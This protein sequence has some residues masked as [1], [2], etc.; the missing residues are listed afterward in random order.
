MKR[1]LFHWYIVVVATSVVAPLCA[2]EGLS[3]QL[4]V[5]RVQSILSEKCWACHGNDANN[6]EGGLDLRSLA[7]A[8]QGGDSGKPAMVVGQPD[9]SPLILASLRTDDTWSAMP[10]KEAEQLTEQQIEWLKSWIETGAAWPDEKRI[11]E[12][13]RSH[14]DAWSAEDGVTVTTSGGLSDE[15]NRR[16]YQPESL[17]AYQPVQKPIVAVTNSAAIDQ[18]I[19]DRLPDGLQVAPAADARTLIRRASFDLIGLPPAPDEIA[20]FEQAFAADEDA[21]VAALIDRLLS[22]PHYGE[23]MAQHW[24]DVV[25]YADSSGFAN[26]YERGNAWRYRDYVVRAFN[27]DKPYDQ[28]VREQLAGDEMDPDDP[29]MLIATGFLRMGPWEL[30]GM[31]VARIARQRFLDDVT[32]SVGETFLAHSLQCARCHDHKFDPVPTRDYYSIQA[33]FATTQLVERAAPFLPHENVSG[34]DEQKYLQQIREEHIATLEQLDATLMQNAAAWFERTGKDATKWN[35]TVQQILQATAG[36]NL[37]PSKKPYDNLF[38]KVRNRLVAQGVPQSEFPPKLVDFT[39]EQFGKERIARK[40]LERLNWELERYQPFALAVYN[41]PT[42]SYRSVNSPLRMPSSDANK[43][44]ADESF[45]LTGGDVFSRAAKV[46][47]GVLSVLGNLDSTIPNQMHGRRLAF[48][49]WVAHEENPLTSRTIVNRIWMWH[50]GIPLAGNPNNFGST[51]KPPTHP[52]LLDYLAATLVESDWSIKSLHRLIMN[53][54]AYRRSATLANIQQLEKLDPLRTS[55]AAFQPRRLS[56]EEL[57]DA[58]LSVSGELNLTL[59]GIPNRPEI[60]LEAALQPRMV[61]G[62]FAAAWVP[63]PLPAQRHRR[64]LYSLKLR[65]LRDPAMEVFNAPAPDFSCERREVSTVTPQVFSLFNGHASYARALALAAR[66]LRESDS[67]SDATAIGRCFELVLGRMPSADELDACLKHWQQMEFEQQ[68]I[69]PVRTT[70]P[71]KVVRHAVEEN[72]GEPF[73]FEETLY[74]NADFVP[75]LQPTDCTVKTRALADICLV[76]FNTNE[77]AYVY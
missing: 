35:T 57:R 55:Y 46:T 4:F 34:F 42:P 9:T 3:A 73:S 60:N 31:E 56:A 72:T 29:E 19:F 45:I 38:A 1:K 77:F 52:E 49:D 58:M 24:L 75:D 37:P 47:P 39:P 36:D 8:L 54:S 64:S 32:N 21:A 69:E 62:T 66:V 15:W 71:L 10:P 33:V 2:D 14:A 6:F 74:A 70:P 5:R 63:N 50:F 22:S 43:N 68:R 7:T 59:G 13:Q 76:L 48:A 27:D 23:R 44:K 41:G 40:G 53:S 18:L 25:R 17:W 16:R 61:M 26:D 51:G 11:A 65:G 28:F 12:I 67:Q 30:T 20:A